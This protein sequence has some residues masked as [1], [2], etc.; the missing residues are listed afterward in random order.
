L[1]QRD[2]W[3]FLSGFENKRLEGA[4]EGL[5][6]PQLAAQALALTVLKVI[7]TPEVGDQSANPL[8]RARSIAKFL[9]QQSSELRRR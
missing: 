2:F 5:G 1:W 7:D 6:Y 4:C 8:E 9:T 3:H